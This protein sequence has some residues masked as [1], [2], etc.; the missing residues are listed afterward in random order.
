MGGAQ[1]PLVCQGRPVKKRNVFFVWSSSLPY[2]CLFYQST[3]GQERLNGLSIF[4]MGNKRN[5]IIDY[6]KTLDDLTNKLGGR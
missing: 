5:L 4:L 3:L 2:A 6:L 1:R